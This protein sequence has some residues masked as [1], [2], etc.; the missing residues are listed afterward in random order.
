MK[1]E[2]NL[3]ELA[4]ATWRLERWLS[5]LNAERKMA[6]KK[7]LRETKKFL[8]ASGVEVVDPIGG[9]FDPGLAVEV[10]NNEEPDIDEDELIIIQTNAPIVKQSGSV[11]QYGKVILGQAVKEQRANNEIRD[12][13]LQIS[14]VNQEAEEVASYELTQGELHIEA[15]YWWKCFDCRAVQEGAQA[16]IEITAN[17]DAQLLL[18]DEQVYKDYCRGYAPRN[19]FWYDCKPEVCYVVLPYPDI[20]YMFAMLPQGCDCRIYKLDM[21]CMWKKLN[22]EQNKEMSADYEK[23]SMNDDCFSSSD[24]DK[25]T[26]TTEEVCAHA[27]NTE[28]S[29]A[30][31]KKTKQLSGEES[32]TSMGSESSISLSEKEFKRNKSM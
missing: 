31:M 28:S 2:P 12:D 11:I 18:M 6:A 23:S 1:E 16:V 20:W 10:V 32:A 22:V 14:H 4:V 21:N 19:P 17:V 8:E 15:D 9:R 26:V 30:N 3:A 27:E 7:S 24:Q 5:N 13:Q 25:K 29:F